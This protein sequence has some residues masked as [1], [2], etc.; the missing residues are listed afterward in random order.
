MPKT[1]PIIPQ[2][3]PANDGTDPP[4][5]GSMLCAD[6]VCTKRHA[7]TVEQIAAIITGDNDLSAAI[8]V[9]ITG[10]LREYAGERFAAQT[11]RMDSIEA[12]IDLQ[13]AATNRM[14]TSTAGIVELMESWAGAMRTI[15][16]TGKVLKPLSL[17]VGFITA[18][19]GL[20]AAVRG[21][22]G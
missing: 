1:I 10:A 12:K 5:L 18:I 11:S 4:R 17:I 19:I 2:V 9:K 21:L 20:V 7:P 6:T 14:E 3:P 16:L 15:E 13:A 8:D 22:G